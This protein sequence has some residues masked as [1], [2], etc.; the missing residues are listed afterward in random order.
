MRRAH[1]ISNEGAPSGERC[2]PSV[3]ERAATSP[4]MQ[5]S[6]KSHDWRKEGAPPLIKVGC[7]L[8]GAPPFQRGAHFP[9]DT[10]SKSNIMSSIKSQSS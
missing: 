2:E 8:K 10:C 5:T 7:Y 6:V 3:R 9:I 1:G 4:H